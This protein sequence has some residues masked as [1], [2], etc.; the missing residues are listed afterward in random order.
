[1]HSLTI[2]ESAEG[3]RS[4]KL[5]SLS[6]IGLVATAIAAAGAPT[7][8]L[9]AAFPVGALTLVT[10]I[11]DAIAAAGTGGTLKAALQAIAD[12]VTPIIVVS[13]AAIGE[14]AEE[15]EDNVIAALD[16][17]KTA[18]SAV[19]VAPRILG[20]PGGLDTL[21]VTTAMVVVA[22]RLR[23][24][25]YA[26]AIAADDAA[27]LLYRDNFSARELMLIW[28]DS[29][30]VVAGDCVARAL[31]LRAQITEQQGWHKTISNVPIDGIVALAQ[32]I[33]FDLLDSST[34]AGLLNA[35]QITTIINH[36]GR[37]FW[38]NRTCAGEDQPE[39]SFES[40]VN[41]SHALQDLIA[42]VFQPFFDQPMTIG[43]VKDLIESANAEARAWTAKGWIMGAKFELDPGTNT[44]EQL[45]AGRPSFRFQYT[46]VA[47]L[48]SPTVK[49]IITD[50]Y[51]SGF[52][53]QLS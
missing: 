32:D 19:G 46:P 37:R 42:S 45:A 52:A 29:S 14:D 9:D 2:L 21:P 30:P 36:D 23:A 35:G 40:A 27:A 25:C 34:Q 22:K 3:P 33:D 43:L 31:G 49:L 41:T 10:N 16:R 38:G 5:P 47:P 6:V 13:R 15:T 4:I 12:Q 53:D 44:A 8:A 28:P 17:L 11:D 1:M 51:Y 48:E 20:V 18:R 24:F 39:F 26:R 50:Y 7:V